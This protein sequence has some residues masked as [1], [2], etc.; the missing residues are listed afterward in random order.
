MAFRKGI[1]RRRG[2][3]SRREELTEMTR[4]QARAMSRRRRREARRAVRPERDLGARVGG[5][6]RET[7]GRLRPLAA[8]LVGLFS[9]IGRPIARGLLFVVQLFAA[10]IALVLEVGQIVV[11]WVGGALMSIALMIA[12][13]TRRHVNPR[14]TVAFV[15]VCAAI[16]LGVSQFFD[17]HGVAVDAPDYA[18]QIG[19]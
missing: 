7:G 2:S 15:G 11:R 5:A 4:A 9:W 1:R 16:G 14:S 10:L 18:G 19:A 8:P 12:E 17:Y 13:A 3:D 6:G